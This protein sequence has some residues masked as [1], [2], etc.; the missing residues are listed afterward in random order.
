MMGLEPTTSR[1]T[2]WRSNQLSYTHH[3]APQGFTSGQATSARPPDTRQTILSGK[4]DTG[5]RNGIS[6]VSPDGTISTT[7][8]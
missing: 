1:S 2:I 4:G 5:R 3:V 6:G 8:V 7:H